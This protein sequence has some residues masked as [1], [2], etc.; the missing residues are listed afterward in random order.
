LWNKFARSTGSDQVFTLLVDTDRETGAVVALTG[1]FTDSLVERFDRNKNRTENALKCLRRYIAIALCQPLKKSLV[2][3][4]HKS[5][6]GC[7]QFFLKVQ[8]DVIPTICNFRF[9]PS[10]PRTAASCA[11]RISGSTE[12]QLSNVN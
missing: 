4:F 1:N 5:V 6:L 7:G 10:P 12:I 3:K 9:F 8:K 2:I 11:Q